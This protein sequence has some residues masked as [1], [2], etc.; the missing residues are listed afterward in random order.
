[1]TYSGLYSSGN[2]FY[3]NPLSGF[4]FESIENQVCKQHRQ[5]CSISFMKRKQ[6]DEF[7]NG[8]RVDSIVEL[9]KV[10]NNSLRVLHGELGQTV[11]DLRY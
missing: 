2:K 6:T 4:Y 1:M 3:L 5:N 8:S 11:L 9:G 7:I 10:R